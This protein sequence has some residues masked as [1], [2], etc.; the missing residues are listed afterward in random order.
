ML[1]S[2]SNVQPYFEG[3]STVEAYIQSVRK[4]EEVSIDSLL[5]TTAFCFI[6]SANGNI[7][8]W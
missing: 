4:D 8:P 6:I 7:K 1:F 5:G 3:V 2:L